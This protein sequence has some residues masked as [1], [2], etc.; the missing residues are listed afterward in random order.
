[1]AREQRLVSAR[2]PIPE[3]MSKSSKE[4]GNHVNLPLNIGT[5]HHNY[6]III[7][8]CSVVLQL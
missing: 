1:M 5:S 3:T 2:L 6:F 4:R 8:G 7:M